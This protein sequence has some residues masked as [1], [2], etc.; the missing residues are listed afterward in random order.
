[1]KQCHGDSCQQGRFPCKTP[2][3]CEVPEPEDYKAEGRLA[4]AIMIV[5]L[6]LAVGLVLWSC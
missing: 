5:C 6:A 2:Q 4:L 3:A 1:M